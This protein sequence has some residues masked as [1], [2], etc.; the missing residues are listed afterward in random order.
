MRE[1]GGLNEGGKRHVKRA[2]GRGL[3]ME[4]CRRKSERGRENGEAGT[5]GRK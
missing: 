5:G 3:G 4:N 1:N 2:T